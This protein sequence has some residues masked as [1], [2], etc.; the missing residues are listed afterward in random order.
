MGFWDFLFINENTEQ[1][2]PEETSD[3][4]QQLPNTIDLFPGLQLDLLTEDGQQLLS[5]VVIAADFPN[6]IIIDRLPGGLSFPVCPEDTP[7]HIHG[8][9]KQTVPFHLKGTIKESS[10]IICKVKDLELQT[11]V[12]GRQTFRL[13]LHVPV[14]MFYQHD[15]YMQNPEK[16][17]MLDISTGGAC[18][19][20]EYIH[21]EGEV[22]R[23][24]AQIEDYAPMTFLGEIIRVDEPSPGVFRY[25]FLFAK[26]KED[27]ITALNRTLYN[28]QVGNRKEWS[29]RTK[30]GNWQ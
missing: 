3:T 2:T 16:C 30:N 9:T 25:G 4:P 22:L 7:V 8:Y 28:L 12:E 6:E 17:T 14:S 11:Y 1:P 10:R 21:A 18:I 5:G 15:K 27:E 26:L 29:R 13:P 24:K 20:S 23:I 19:E